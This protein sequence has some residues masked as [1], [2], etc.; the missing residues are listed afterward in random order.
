MENEYRR[1]QKGWKEG[2]R[3]GEGRKRRKEGGTKRGR[4]KGRKRRDIC[5]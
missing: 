4:R 2:G 3:E 1:R 5:S